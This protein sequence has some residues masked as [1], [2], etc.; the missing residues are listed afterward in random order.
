MKFMYRFIIYLLLC[1]III[2]IF[3]MVHEFSHVIAII[4]T[5]NE[6]K[7]FIFIDM[8]I[9]VDAEYSNIKAIPIIMIAGSF[10]IIICSFVMKGCDNKIVK[11]SAQRNGI[12]TDFGFYCGQC[13][14]IFLFN[15]VNVFKMRLD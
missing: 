7:G 11:L 2:F 4:L 9:L 6:W 8:K 15:Y 14:A 1:P 5:G 10:G 12:K 13:N 3:I